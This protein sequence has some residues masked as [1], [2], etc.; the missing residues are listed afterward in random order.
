MP[1]RGRRR[2]LWVAELYKYILAE[3]ERL[4]AANVKLSPS[5]LKAVAV[6]Q[7]QTANLHASYNRNV[8]INNVPITN[9]ITIPMDSTVHV[10]TQPCDSTSG[11][12]ACTKF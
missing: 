12:E 11:R 6:A 10:A 9:K 3:F 2:A 8:L 5:I 1:G 4:R 7:I